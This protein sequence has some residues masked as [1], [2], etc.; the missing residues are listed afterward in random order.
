M[1]S[2]CSPLPVAIAVPPPRQKGTSEPNLAPITC[3]SGRVKPNSHIK[4]SPTN[5][6]AALADPPAKPAATGIRL[7]M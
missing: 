6:P 1:G 4:F 5:T 3:N 7:S 2:N